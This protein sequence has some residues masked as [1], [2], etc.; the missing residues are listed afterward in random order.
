MNLMECVGAVRRRKV[1]VVAGT[2]GTVCVAL[3]LAVLWPKTYRAEAVLMI[4]QSIIPTGGKETPPDPRVLQSFGSTYERL[5]SSKQILSAATERFGL[6]EA[7]HE[8][9]WHSLDR[10]VS[11][12]TIRGSRLMSVAA[13]LPEPDLARDVANFIA[14]Q[15]VDTATELGTTGA[16][17]SQQILREKLSAARKELQ[18]ATSSLEAFRKK[19]ALPILRRRIDTLLSRND[20]VETQIAE[21]E[22]TISQQQKALTPLQEALAEQE[23]TLYLRRSLAR[24]DLYQQLL[25]AL[26]NQDQRKLYGLSMVSQEE[27]PTFTH[28]KTNE[29]DVRSELAGLTAKAVSLQEELSDNAQ[30]LQKLQEELVSGELELERK[31]GEYD[32]KRDHYSRLSRK[33]DEV[34][35]E[36]A[37]RTQ[38]LKLVDRA[39]TPVRAA[40][41]GP[42]R[43]VAAALVGGPALF[44]VLAC[45]LQYAEEE[46]VRN[47]ASPAELPVEES[48]PEQE[49]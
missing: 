6:G 22:A 17:K 41:P 24:D 33:L 30:R 34:S 18:A 19:A 37:S 35:V 14:E 49:K 25:A 39:L 47:T 44:V 32:L 15:A 36:V 38:D 9:N 42:K 28:L 10:R 4:E 5:V 40:G 46:Q 43:V 29:V 7:P 1:L 13:E 20:R 48:A 8:L 27:N 45:L 16:E 23:P 2:V 21:I 26:S 31:K 3:L 12:D 11:V